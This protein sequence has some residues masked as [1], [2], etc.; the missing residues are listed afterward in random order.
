[1][2]SQHAIASARFTSVCQNY[3]DA[4]ATL[5]EQWLVPLAR[6]TLAVDR[7]RLTSTRGIIVPHCCKWRLLCARKASWET[8]MIIAM[9]VPADF[10]NINKRMGDIDLKFR[11]T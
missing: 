10:N 2:I 7:D 8:H 11:Q 9:L 1:M 6:V 3:G 4:S 5:N